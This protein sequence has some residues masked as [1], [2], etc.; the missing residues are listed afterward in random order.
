MHM[1]MC[2]CHVHVYVHVHAHVHVHVHGP[3]SMQVDDFLAEMEAGMDASQDAWRLPTVVQAPN[4]I[5]VSDT[6][7]ADIF[8]NVDDYIL[9]LMHGQ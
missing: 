5:L 6:G 8:E 9:Q 1:Y 3:P 2:T 7:E 4:K